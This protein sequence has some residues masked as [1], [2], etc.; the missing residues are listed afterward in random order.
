MP[1]APQQWPRNRE[2]SRYPGIDTQPGDAH[3]GT[4]PYHHRYTETDLL[5]EDAEVPPRADAPQDEEATDEEE[6]GSD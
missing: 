3:F 6:S 2:L 5:P 1:L 4:G